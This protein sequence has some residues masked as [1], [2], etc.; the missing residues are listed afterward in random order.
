MRNTENDTLNI[1]PRWHI[2]NAGI[3]KK[4]TND[5]TN[6]KTSIYC[7]CVFRKWKFLEL[8]IWNSMKNVRTSSKIMTDA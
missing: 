5:R 1:I 8:H 6:E 2:L 4:P 7:V 3:R